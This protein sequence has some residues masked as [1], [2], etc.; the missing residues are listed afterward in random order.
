ML[1]IS[2]MAALE[3]GTESMPTLN[4]GAFLVGDVVFRMDDWYPVITH[5][6]LGR[7]AVG[8]RIESVQTRRLAE[9]RAGVGCWAWIGFVG[10]LPTVISG[11]ETPWKG[12]RS[13]LGRT[14]FFHDW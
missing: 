7:G 14:Q 6:R 1:A 13:P 4:E 8:V 10:P 3:L 12:L 9:A 11:L 5:K 2:V